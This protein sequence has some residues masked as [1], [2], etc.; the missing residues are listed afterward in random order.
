MAVFGDPTGAFISA[1]QPGA[2]A[3]FEATGPDAFVWVELNAREADRAIAFYQAVFGWTA[4]SNDMGV[5]N[6]PYIEFQLD[7]ESIA[8]GMEMMPTVPAEV[9]SYW[10]A[11]FGVRDVDAA[12]AKAVE[13]GHANSSPQ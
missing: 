5:G 3:G 10:I 9:P 13:L 12:F 2:M 4:K 1:W 8:G 6:P 11:Y 7:G